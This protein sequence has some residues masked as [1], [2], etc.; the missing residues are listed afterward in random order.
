MADGLEQLERL[1]LVNSISREVE[2]HMGLVSEAGTIAEFLISLHEDSKSLD[3]FKAK[4][5][6]A[7]AEFPASFVTNV[8]RL[9]LSLHPRYKKKKAGAANGTN[10]QDKGKG[11]SVDEASLTDQQR[12]DRALF[13]GLAIPDS[14]WQPSFQPDEGKQGAKERDL[15]EES[16]DALMDELSGIN[17]KRKQVDNGRPTNGRDRDR[18]RSPKRSRR[19]LSVSPPRVRRRSPDYSGSRRGDPYDDD[20]RGRGRDRDRRPPPLDERPV[21]YKIYDGTVTSLK[22]FGVF[23]SLKGIAGRAEGM[24]HVSSLSS[25]RVNHPSDLVSRNQPVKV[26]VMSVAG[27]RIGLSMKDVDQATGADLTPHLRIKSEAEMAAEAAD[28]AAKH[29]TGAN[30]IGGQGRTFADDHR[31]TAKRLTSPERW[32]IKQL[33]ASGA[34]KASDYPNLDED[35]STPGN[36]RGMAAA[37]EAEEELDVEMREEEA[38][39]LKGAAKRALDLSPVKIVKNPDGSLNRAAVAGAGYAKERREL[40]QQEANDRADAETQDTNSAWLDPAAKPHERQFA[41]DA[42]DDRMSRRKDDETGWKASIQNKATT[43]GRVTSLS[44]VEQRQSLPVYKLRDEL[45]KAVRENQV[46]VVVGDTG[47]GKTTQMT[48]YLAEEG[49]ADR[50]KIGCTQPRRVAAMSVAKRVAEEVGCRLGQE[51]GYTIRFE[52]CTSPETKIKYMTDGMLQREALIDPDL[53]AYSIIILDEAHE[54]TIATDV[55]FGLLKSTSSLWSAYECAADGS[56][57]SRSN[58]D[59]I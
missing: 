55:L 23:V 4:L 5:A 10:G 7:G 24:V 50:G 17:Q 49:F 20:L 58:V 42:R 15:G 16:V 30:A 48:Q 21:L 29:A 32:E 38:P 56:L 3:G 13:P 41:Q 35:F 44:L 59:R 34:A 37:A 25:G 18:S 19:D 45:V 6:E 53:L 9:I 8:D 22:D 51:V 28:F 11:K 36:T 40:R 52:D 57:Q 33:I 47:S 39:F 26:K 54:R 14:E 46:M 31:N 43:Y 12:K 1:A 2:N 27:T